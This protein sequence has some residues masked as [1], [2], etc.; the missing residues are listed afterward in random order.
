MKVLDSIE[1]YILYV[2]VGIYPIFVLLT[3][4]SP[5]SLPKAI[6]L[7][8]AI[9][10]LLV[11]WLIQ[12]IIK[13]SINFAVGK[14]DLGVLLLILVYI[15]GTIF[16]TPNKMEAILIPGMTTFLVASGLMYFI[17][18]QLDKAG[19]KAVLVS[20]FVSGIIYALTILLTQVGLFSKIPQLP[21]A[22]KDPNFNPLGGILPGIF[23]LAPVLAIG[24]SL[25]LEEKDMVKRTFWAVSAAVTLLAIGILIVNGLPGKPQAPSFPG[26]ATSWEIAVQTIARAPVFGAGP[27]N[28]LTAFNLFRPVTYNSTGLWQLR[29]TTGSDFYLTLLTE[30]GLAGAVAI[31]ILL[32]AVYK[33]ITKNWR[34]ETFEKIALAIS[35]I[36]LAIFPATATILL[37]FFILLAINSGSTEKSFRIS[38]LPIGELPTN[39]AHRLP[40]IIVGLVI[41]IAVGF[42]DF[43]GTKIILAEATFYNSIIALNNNDA[44]NTYNLMQSAINQNPQVDRYHASFAQVDMALAQS[45]ASKTNLTDADRTTITQLVQQAINEGKSTVILNQ[46]RSGN[47]QIL[48]AIYRSIMPFAQGADQ[49]TVQTYT[50]AVALDPTDPN[51]RI[52]LGGVYYALGRFQD[53]IDAFKLAAVAKPDLANAHY[54]LAIAYRE[55]KDF[56]NAISEM[57]NVL[58]LVQPNTQ[59]YTLA[60]QTLDDLQK[61]KA[62][63]ATGS[64][65]LKAPQPIGP[66]N[67]KPPITLPQ[68][69]TP[70]A[71][72]QPTTP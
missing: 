40:I 21:A 1:K 64:A 23:Y 53:A 68:E 65:N 17:V 29:F 34:T 25:I 35:V 66:S 33:Y 43:F 70:P 10:I 22:I 11:L 63:T 67:V 57:N 41:L 4:S 55:N 72:T 32:V 6:L 19:K 48:A 56:D 30:T 14:F 46:G 44:K 28:Y 60:K 27:G 42:T 62:T 36:L 61:N 20:L 7:T 2:V 54:N 26:F 16:A 58:S 69:A 59:D 38:S 51:V 45:I 37:P 49:F 50:Q 15:A 24:V 18:N 3:I 52:A 39:I 13:G 9:S 31:A 5:A 12:A 47:W 8:V 71:N